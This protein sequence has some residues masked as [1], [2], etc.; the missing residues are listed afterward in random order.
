MSAPR[1]T[2]E[3]L[4]AR[5]ER[6]LVLLAWFIELDGDVYVPLYEQFERELLELKQREATKDRARRLLDS[7]RQGETSLLPPPPSARWK[8]PAP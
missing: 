5:I 2:P 7:Y 6:A 3:N 8:S 1:H 4:I